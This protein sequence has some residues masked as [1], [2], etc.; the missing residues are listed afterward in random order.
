MPLKRTFGGPTA[1]IK[2]PVFSDGDA[3]HK[4][5]GGS[6]TRANEDGYLQFLAEKWMKE[7]VGGAQRGKS[8]FAG[9]NGEFLSL[10]LLILIFQVLCFL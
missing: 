8:G 10:C 6:L 7:E 3:S 1:A 4:P 9:R 5:E 2:G